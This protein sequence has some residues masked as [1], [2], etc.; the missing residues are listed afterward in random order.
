[1]ATSR[2]YKGQPKP[3]GKSGHF[4][5]S[6][7]HALQAKGYKTGHLAEALFLP[8]IKPNDFNRILS[9]IPTK[10]RRDVF[11]RQFSKLTDSDQKFVVTILKDTDEDRAID[12][13]D[14]NPYDPTKQDL[15]GFVQQAG[16]KLK[17]GAQWV[18]EK[19]REGAEWVKKELPVAEEKLKEGAIKAEE[20]AKKEY[21]EIKKDIAELKKAKA[22]EE[23]SR[24]ELRREKLYE[25]VGRKAPEPEPEEEPAPRTTYTNKPRPE[26]PSEEEEGEEPTEELEETEEDYDSSSLPARLGTFLADLTDSYTSE[27]LVGLSDREL[28]MLAV[29]FKTQT[30]GE[31]SLFGGEPE[32]PFLDELKNR[33]E[34]R[35]EL[36]K[37]KA[38]IRAELKKPKKEDKGLLAD[39]FG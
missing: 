24:A 23:E 7:R 9:R 11:Q 12:L 10:K 3:M 29:R 4:F 37:E 21:A 15:K 34:A 26:Q 8:P 33:I 27:D 19:A 13:F 2:T 30:K 5:E 25:A 36:K 35:A 38:E 17:E 32:N 18:G 6:K 16:E 31:V 22:L 39:F 1:M 28:E 20:F 14:C